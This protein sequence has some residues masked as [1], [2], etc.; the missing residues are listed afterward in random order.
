MITRVGPKPWETVVASGPMHRISS[1]C[2]TT[3]LSRST[4]YKLMSDGL[5]PPTVKMGLHSSAIPDS[6]LAAYF[7]D[8][9]CKAL[10]RV[11]A[12]Q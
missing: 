2:R 6:W 10:N 9:G 1:V 3:G 4:I 8:Q 7:A 12:K 5:F 11:G